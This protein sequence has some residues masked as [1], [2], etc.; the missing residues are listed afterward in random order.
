MSKKV[1][2]ISASP[3]E[4]GNSDYLCDQFI[5][6]AQ[7]AGHEVEK[8]FI[9]DYEIGFCSGCG[10]CNQTH[11][12]VLRDDMEKLL[13]KLINADVIVLASPVYFYTID[14]QMKTFIDRTVPRYQEIS[15]KELYFIVTAADTEVAN[16]ERAVECFRGYAD[17]LPGAQEKGVIYGAGVWQKGEIV[18]KPAAKQAYAMGKNL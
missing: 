12:C 2:V 8:L 18:G 3:R 16:L 13:P 11:K 1:L 15:N 9:A 17:C 5:Q 10:V 7:E 6:G 4:G 14:G